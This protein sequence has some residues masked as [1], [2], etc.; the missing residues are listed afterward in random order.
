MGISLPYSYLLE[1]TDG[2]VAHRLEQAAHNHLVEGSIPSSP[3]TEPEQMA[4]SIMDLLFIVTITVSI[5]VLAGGLIYLIQGPPYVPLRNEPAE[6]MLKLINK[7]Q[8]KYILDMGSGDGRLVILLAKKG[9]RVDGVELN[10]WLVWR[11]RRAIK[12]AG[13]GDHAHIYW[14]NFWNFPVERYDMVTLYVTQ[15][16]MPRLEAKLLAELTPGAHIVSNF[17]TFPQLQPSARSGKVVLYTVP[18]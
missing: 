4:I 6:H 11:S 17:F 15:H 12:K 8:P 13:V 14:G 2:A 3:T 1:F 9:Y 7:Q 16:I 5:A 18:D 10:P